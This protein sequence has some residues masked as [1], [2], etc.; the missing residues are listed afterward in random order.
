MSG[1]ENW[2]S[3]RRVCVIGAGT[4]G[5]GIAAH[6][7]NL[8]FEVTLLD[9]TP[10]SVEA[11][12][13]RAKSARPPHF[14]VPE[15]A[16]RIRLGSIQENL[17]WVQEADWVCEAIIE[18]LDAKQELFAKLDGL[19]PATTAITTNTSGLEIRLLCEGRSDSFRKR[20]MGTHFFNPPRYLK[21]LELIPT[22]STDSEA[23]K[24][25][26]QFLEEKVARR[27]VVAK[28]TPGFIANRY[29]MWSM[30]HATH[31]AEKLHLTVEQ[32]DAITGPFL[33]RPRTGSFRLNDL[34]GLDIM[35]DIAKNLQDRCPNDKFIEALN[36]PKSLA[37]LHDRGWKG[38]KA[39]QGY[40]RREG[41]EL[42]AFDLDTHAYRQRMEPSFANMSMLMELPL[43]ERLK[44]AIELR[45]EIGEYLREYLIPALQYADYLKEEISFNIQD[46]DRVMQWGF[47]WELGPF[48]MRDILGL[49]GDK[50]HYK[51][52]TILSFSGEYVPVPAEPQYRTIKEY[53]LLE[54]GEY[55][56]LR[57]LGD[58]VTA[59]A[60]TSKMGT[61]SPELL[62]ELNK[63]LDR[64]EGPFVLTS[65]AKHFSLGFDLN[66]FKN[67]IEAEQWDE[68][69]LALDLLQQTAVRLSRTK[70]VACL[71]GYTLGAGWE[72]AWQCP[73]VAAHCDSMI[74]FPEI[75][76]GLI[77]GGGGTSEM[78]L[79]A[80][81]KG[82]K[83]MVEAAKTLVL[84]TVTDNADSARNCGYL[85]P[86]DVTLYNRD[87]LLA[88][89]TKL[90]KLINVAERE[91]WVKVEGPLLGMID[92]ME[93]ELQGK[94]QLT[95]YDLTV[96]EKVKLVF[97]RST[98]FEDA[99]V[100]ERAHFIELCKK[101]LTL[102]RIKHMLE[103][104]K[105]LRN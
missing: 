12:F 29:G 47:G 65:E 78:A 45:D 55:I 99:L 92:R 51:E 41:K 67:A 103:T 94:D 10:S 56:N 102:T 21:L 53:P 1:Y 52:G 68:I 28:D 75:R 6:L 96:S 98:S 48:A 31:V 2:Q 8:G 97:S 39:G 93:A 71:H 73:V 89:A 101:A 18:K 36:T 104:G 66:F 5:S 80:T 76:V 3:I 74:G 44:K 64:F 87:S 23:V 60:L 33:G 16:N 4:M 30:F 54:K 20:F 83:E 63:V 40:Y 43:A 59:L 57:D 34:V 9:L 24:A 27:V 72:L 42:V 70:I 49:S 88:D 84:G 19:L 38:E 11:A 91:T 46:F 15:T 81:K 14:F 25:M 90:A 85:R 86:T 7:A 50:P 100:K 58:G 17:D 61:I 37:Y 69:D 13:E 35:L 95:E 79:R 82:A 77:P 32:V 22:D 26:A 105:P 62:V